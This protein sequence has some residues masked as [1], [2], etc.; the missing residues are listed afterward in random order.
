MTEFVIGEPLMNRVEAKAKAKA[1]AKQLK[2]DTITASC[3]VIGDPS[4]RA[5][6]GLVFSGVRPGVDGT[7][8]VITSATARFSKQGF[9]TS[10]DA[11]LKV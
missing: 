5:G 1:K 4:V 2:R 9:T 11:E 6:M 3:E 7:K 10:I 8:F